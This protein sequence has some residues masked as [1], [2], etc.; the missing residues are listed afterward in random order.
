MAK[1][2]E[3]L[4]LF[5]QTEDAQLAERLMQTSAQYKIIGMYRTP[6]QYVNSAQVAE[7]LVHEVGIRNVIEFCVTELERRSANKKG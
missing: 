7:V 6:D 2:S 1:Q 5:K 3:Q 4:D